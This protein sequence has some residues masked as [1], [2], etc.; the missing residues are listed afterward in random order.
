M[1]SD[2]ATDRSAAR[3]P[4]PA[5]T[6][7]PHTDFWADG[8]SLRASL[9]QCTGLVTPQLGTALCFSSLVRHLVSAKLARLDRVFARFSVWQ[10]WLVKAGGLTTPDSGFRRVF[11]PGTSIA[12]PLADAP[13]ILSAEH[14]E[15]A[16]RPA[17]WTM[18]YPYTQDGLTYDRPLPGVACFQNSGARTS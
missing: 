8:W 2:N 4:H 6:C 14:I 9:R 15:D 11:R 3:Q 5:A 17:T 18:Q 1:N 12:V 13:T 16:E 7:G 10:T